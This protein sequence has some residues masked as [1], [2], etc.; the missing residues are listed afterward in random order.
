MAAPANSAS[1][2]DE[3]TLAVIELTAQRVVREHALSGCPHASTIHD[4]KLDVYGGAGDASN[5]GL[6][7]RVL[8]IQSERV[9]TWRL[10]TG[11]AAVASGV[12]GVI[13]AIVALIGMIMKIGT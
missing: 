8:K 3:H 11:I 12:G 7:G 6:K 5:G 9:M 4:L 13:G 10:I 1:H 2:V